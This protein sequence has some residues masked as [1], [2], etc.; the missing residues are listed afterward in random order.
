MSIRFEI[1]W[2]W[3]NK[4]I[5]FWVHPKS[6]VK[7]VVLGFF[8]SMLSVLLH[9]LS[10]AGIRHFTRLVCLLPARLSSVLRSG[11]FSLC[12]SYRWELR[13]NHKTIHKL[14]NTSIWNCKYHT[15]VKKSSWPR[16]ALS[17]SVWM[18]FCW[19]SLYTTSS[20][21]THGWFLLLSSMRVCWEEQPTWIPSFSSARR[22]VNLIQAV[23]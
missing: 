6:T 3:A 5:K 23:R 19:V 17:L 9:Y 16:I 18:L 2:D 22:C 7:V 14:N 21:Q 8:T 1:W 20:C 10:S 13:L 11:K 12:L 15:L 4:K